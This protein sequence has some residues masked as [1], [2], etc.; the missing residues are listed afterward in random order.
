MNQSPQKY[1]TFIA[2]FKRLQQQQQQQQLQQRIPIK[3]PN[4]WYF[5]WIFIHKPTKGAKWTIQWRW[6]FKI[7]NFNKHLLLNIYCG[8]KIKLYCWNKSSIP[9]R[10]IHSNYCNIYNQKCP[11]EYEFSMQYFIQIDRFGSDYHV[12]FHFEIN[13]IYVKIN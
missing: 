12:T 11:L 7:Y 3:L 13:N 8:N 1:L 2:E 9:S 4:W 6:F 10:S 5:A